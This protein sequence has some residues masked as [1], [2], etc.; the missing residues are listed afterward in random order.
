ML[1]NISS[2]FDQFVNNSKTL[3]IVILLLVFTLVAT[4]QEQ[5]SKQQPDTS[6]NLLRLHGLELSLSKPEIQFPMS[7]N[8]SQENFRGFLRQS[9]TA[10]LPIHSMQLNGNLDFKSIWQVE[11][12]RQNEYR[13]LKTILTS[14]QVGGVAYLTYLHLKKYGLK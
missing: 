8:I 12:A 13:T 14:V 6:M 4:G 1:V 2:C 11:L 7:P 5:K 9:L 10:P 3:Q